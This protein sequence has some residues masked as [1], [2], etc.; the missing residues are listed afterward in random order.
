VEI[1]HWLMVVVLA[2]ILLAIIRAILGH[3]KPK[4]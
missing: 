1:F 4:L 3:T 2:L